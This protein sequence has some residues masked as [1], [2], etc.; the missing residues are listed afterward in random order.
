MHDCNRLQACDRLRIHSCFALPVE[1][2]LDDDLAC[3]LVAVQSQMKLSRR[4]PGD[5]DQADANCTKHKA[6]KDK[7]ITNAVVRHAYPSTASRQASSI[8]EL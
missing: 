3:L 7:Q 5:G 8:G 1:V 6:Y 4:P 2:H